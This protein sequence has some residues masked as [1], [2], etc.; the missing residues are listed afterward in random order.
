[1]RRLL[2]A[3]LIAVSAAGCASVS[4]TANKGAAT[5]GEALLPTSEEVKLGNQLAA[6]VTQDEKVLNNPAVQSYV[7]KVGQRLVASTGNDRRSGI[8]YTFTVIDDPRQ[9]NA[10]ALPGGH[11]YV[12]SGLLQAAD[13][14]AELAGVLGHEIGHV[15]ER[16]AAAALGAQFG[17]QT[18]T[19]LA[20]GQNPG[21][22]SQ[23]A[24]GIAQQ[25][26]MSKHS[27][28]A[29]RQADQAGLRYMMAAGYDPNA[30]PTFFR[31]LERLGGSN[32]NA[33]QAFFASHPAPG[34]RAKTL[35]KEIAAKRA[36]GR[37]E[38]IGGFSQMKA[39]LASGAGSSSG[40]TT[41]P[42][43]SGSTPSGSTSGGT[44]TAPRPK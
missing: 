25:G 5:L 36:T 30:M 3:L 15:T 32:P 23:L 44:Q 9:V 37:E 41:T 19:Q 28:D 43:P 16:H 13:S 11:I 8:N 10:F 4:K 35:S 38:I 2:T 17:L 27:R 20:L 24:A 21:M 31:K 6:E 12:Y 33:L 34:E 14:E 7:N 18:V 42:R 40:T 1:M 39:Q 26:Y 29:E 22:L